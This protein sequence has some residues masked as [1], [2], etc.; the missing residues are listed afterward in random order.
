MKIVIDLSNIAYICFYGMGYKNDPDTKYNKEEYV[1]TCR[2]K[3]AAIKYYTNSTETIF[4]K[5]NL[6]PRKDLDEN[7][8]GNRKDI[9]FPIKEDLI[10]ALK[11]DNYKICEAID[12]EADDVMATL[13]DA[14]RVD[15]IVSTDQDLLQVIKKDDQMFN[16]ITMEFWDKN[17]LAK[18]F[19]GLQEYSNIVYHKTFF[20]DSSDNIPKIGDRLPRKVILEKINTLQDITLAKLLSSLKNEAFY[21]K[22]NKERAFLNFEMVKLD[23]KC[24]LKLID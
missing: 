12:K 22:I 2:N 19:D 3:I 21:S 11:I 4:A 13:L 1:E 15:C 7:Y 18:K 5:D 23:K 17:K 16:P 10:E 9:I 14:G 6:T 8:K 20:G 24:K